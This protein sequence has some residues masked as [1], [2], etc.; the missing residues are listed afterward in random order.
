MIMVFKRGKKKMPGKAARERRSREN[1][2]L[3]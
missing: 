2:P 1:I 3:L